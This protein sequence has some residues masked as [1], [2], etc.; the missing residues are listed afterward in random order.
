MFS[1]RSFG[2]KPRSLFKRADV[3][4]VQSVSCEAKVEQVLLKCGC[5]R[6]LSRGRQASEPNGAALLLAQL[7]TLLTG[8]TR[9]PCDV[10]CH[11]RF[12][13]WFDRY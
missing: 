7:A 1:S 2:E 9:V 5:N 11:C 8:E 13:S 3:V 10:G 4:A 6:R 12:G